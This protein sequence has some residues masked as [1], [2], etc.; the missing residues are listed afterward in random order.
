MRLGV[1]PEKLGWGV[2]GLPPKTLALFMKKVCDVRYPI[3]D[4][5][6]NSKD[7]GP[8]SRKARKLIGLE[9]LF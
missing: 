6:K 2:R 7:L 8:V 3:Y 4:L 9:K 5:T 1:L